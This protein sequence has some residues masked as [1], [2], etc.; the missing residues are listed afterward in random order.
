MTIDSHPGFPYAPDVPAPPSRPAAVNRSVVFW[1]LAVLMYAVG[2]VAVLA[3]G[4]DGFSREVAEI[5]AASGPGMSPEDARMV[6]TIGLVIGGVVA[7]VLLGLWVLFIL[8]MRAGRSWARA[9]LTLVAAPY[10]ALDGWTLATTPV[11]TS[12]KLTAASTAL[13]AA[14]MV[15][16]WLPGARAYFRR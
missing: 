9:V 15:F 14:A 12:W 4:A 16:M 8:K 2:L 13:V 6:V 1:L 5:A 11:D 7:V 10:L 3:T